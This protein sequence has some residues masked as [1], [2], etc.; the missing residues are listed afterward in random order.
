MI[1]ETAQGVL[2]ALNGSRAA[3]DKARMAID[4]ADID[5]KDARTDLTQVSTLYFF[6]IYLSMIHTLNCNFSG[7]LIQNAVSN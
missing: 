2:W 7:H 4:Q 1:L 5:I 3:Q 6:I